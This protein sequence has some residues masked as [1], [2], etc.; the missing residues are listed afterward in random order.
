MMT[1]VGFDVSTRQ[2]RD[3]KAGIKQAAATHSQE[4]LITAIAEYAAAATAAGLQPL[5]KPAA[6]AALHRPQKQPADERTAAPSRPA[7]AKRRDTDR[8]R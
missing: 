3:Y 4:T 1:D 8:G 5:G 2:V 7:L 6:V